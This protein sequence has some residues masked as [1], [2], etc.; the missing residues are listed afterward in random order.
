[1]AQSHLENSGISEQ[2]SQFLPITSVHLPAKQ[3]R[4]YFDPTKLE[5]LVASI[6]QYGVIEPLIVRPISKNT[7][8]LVAGERRYRAAKEVGLT[9]IPVVIRELNEQQAFELALLENLQRDDLNPIDETEGLLDLLSQALKFSREEV[10]SLLNR[11]A[12]AQKR[13][14]SLT[15][16][17]TRQIQVVDNLFQS[18]GRLNRESFRTNRLPLLKMPEDVLQILRQGQLEYTKAKAISRVSDEGRRRV[19]MSEAIEEQLSLRDIKARIA[20]G[21]E[22]SKLPSSEKRQEMEMENPAE[23]NDTKPVSRSKGI[24]DEVVELAL[25]ETDAWNEDGK[26]QKIRELLAEIRRILESKP[27]L[28]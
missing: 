26:R 22:S 7:Y 12:N 18:V 1:M 17:D 23:K 4:R 10:V 11:V 14:K 8:E 28:L 3:P 25:L 20:N 24:R 9:K 27:P 15:N 21:P 2:A 16:N 13:G 5:Q 19:L 6:R